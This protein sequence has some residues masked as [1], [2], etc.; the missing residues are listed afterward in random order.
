M[1]PVGVPRRIPALRA[2]LGAAACL[3]VAAGARTAQAQAPDSTFSSDPTW[4]PD[5]TQESLGSPPAPEREP[6]LKWRFDGAGLLYGEKGRAKVI[7]P[8]ARITRLFPDGQ[9]FSA[10]L[11]LDVI[12][13]ASPT[14]AIPSS[15]VQTTTTASGNV[16]TSVANEVPTHP[17]ND[18]RG[19]LDLEWT[20]PFGGWLTPTLGTHA[21]VEKDYRSLGGTAKLSL[22]MMHRLTTVTLGAG[23]N[24]DRVDP[25]GGTRA[26]LSDG[27]VLLT[28][29]P[30]A[31]R[32][33]TAMAGV[34]RVLTRRWLFGVNGSRSTEHGYLTDPYKVISVLDATGAPVGQLTDARP[35]S[36]TRWDVLASSVYHLTRNVVYASYRYYWDDWGVT[37]HTADT[38]YRVELPN[39]TFVQPHIRYYFQTRANFFQFGLPQGAPL[40][41]FAT[42]DSR[43][44]DLRTLTLGATYGFHPTGGAGELSLRAEY[45]RQWGKGSGNQEPG[46]F[47]GEGGTASSGPVDFI[48]PEDIGSIVVG[49]SVPF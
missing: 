41:E 8:Q 24:E 36:R 7:E 20:K 49:Y 35:S 16:S 2:R 15:V 25:V 46:E 43:L 5:S 22:A 47:E 44:G 3:L 31:K 40:P 4:K 45:I 30:S 17:F 18:M 10:T 32:V 28:T 29:D 11:G 34:S 38:R 48:P 42:S 19:G 14:G 39:Q 27:S 13:G 12:T 21:S 23:Y 26:P 33:R 1:S 6:A 37:S 9:S